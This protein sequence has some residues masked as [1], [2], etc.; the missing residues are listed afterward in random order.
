[1]KVSELSSILREYHPDEDIALISASNRYMTIVGV[2][3]EKTQQNGTLTL[4]V[5]WA[6]GVIENEELRREREER[7]EDKRKEKEQK[8]QEKKIEKLVARYVQ[9]AHGENVKTYRKPRTPDEQRA[10]GL[11]PTG[12]RGRPRKIENVEREI[13]ELN[14]LSPQ[15]IDYLSKRAGE[16]ADNAD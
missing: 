13:Q 3:V 7:I 10:A 5:D 12:R 8:R 9:G 1:M 2:D 11:V 14:E 15:I 4:L 16:S 6:G